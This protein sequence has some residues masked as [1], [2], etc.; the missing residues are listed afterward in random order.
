[1]PLLLLLSS[2]GALLLVL[3]GT[4]RETRSSVRPSGRSARA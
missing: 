3:T 2:A 1:L 4:R